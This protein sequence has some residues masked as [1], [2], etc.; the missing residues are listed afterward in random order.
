ML[1]TF[2]EQDDQI[3]YKWSTWI[4]NLFKLENFLHIFIL[5]LVHV[6]FSLDLHF[7]VPFTDLSETTTTVSHTIQ[8]NY[9]QRQNV[10]PGILF[11][12]IFINY[13]SIYQNVHSFT[14]FQ[15]PV[16]SNYTTFIYV[17][18]PHKPATIQQIL[19]Y[20]YHLTNKGKLRNTV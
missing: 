20:I 9:Q 4:H 18:F 16:I 11:Y 2:S 7:Q 1:P 19:G 15:T 8:K 13:N 10:A 5:S 17:F 14:Y 3:C 6:V 12:E